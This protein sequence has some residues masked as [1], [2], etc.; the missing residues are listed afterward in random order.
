MAIKS[1]KEVGEEAAKEVGNLF[2]DGQRNIMESMKAKL[3]AAGLS[4]R[5]AE[6]TAAA[7]FAHF[8]KELFLHMASGGAMQGVL[9]QQG[10]PLSKETVDALF[11]G[12]TK[13][14]NTGLK[15]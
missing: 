5:D 9:I 12:I 6:D 10:P 2:T 8:Y 3:L 7:A 11:S 13:A 15:N 14:P 1:A 4:E